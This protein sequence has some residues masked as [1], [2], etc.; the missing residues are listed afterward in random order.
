MKQIIYAM[1]FKGQGG[2]GGSPNVLK[3]TTSSPSCTVTSVI[4]AEGCT[5]ACSRRPAAR[6]RSS[7]R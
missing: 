7:Q 1:Q 5:A 4:G 2:P 6:R 3:A